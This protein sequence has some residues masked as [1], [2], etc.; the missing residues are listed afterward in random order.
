MQIR[1]R[2]PL[3]DIT[4]AYDLIPTSTLRKLVSSSASNSSPTL[5]PP[6]SILKPT[7]SFRGQKVSADSSPTL[8]GLDVRSDTS[9]GSSVNNAHA[10]TSTT[11]RFLNR[12]FPATSTTR[13]CNVMLSCLLNGCHRGREL[14]SCLV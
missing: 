2:K 7:A 1:K 6:I 13:D 10:L 5:K 9:I 12:K 8:N 14:F 11:V 3:S 4:N